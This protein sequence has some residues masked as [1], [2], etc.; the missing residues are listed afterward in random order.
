MK[1]AETS[2]SW[3]SVR[4]EVLRRIHERIWAP[5]DQIP[6]E[7][8]L[9]SEFGCAR[10][11]VNRALREIAETG[12]IER[13]RRA[14]TRV[15]LHP[16]RKATLNIPVI[17]SEIEDL[18]KTYSFGLIQREDVTP[19]LK[20]RARFQIAPDRKLLHIVGLHLADGE[21]HVLEDRWIDPVAIPEALRTD[22][23]QISPN[24]WLVTNIPFDGG[25][26]SFSAGA[27][28]ED[29]ASALGC[30]AGAPTFVVERTTW[31]DAG[32]LTIVR[33]VFAPGYRLQTQI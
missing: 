26:I 9:A 3:Q 17:R 1:S 2:V 10:T 28:G 31:N 20:V 4:S 12:L 18:G 16:V 14:G 7:A 15:A 24:E 22:F 11:T 27:A 6:H 5:G 19:P 25:D 30:T 21:P 33:L 8:E 32:T 13:R 23:A 29:E